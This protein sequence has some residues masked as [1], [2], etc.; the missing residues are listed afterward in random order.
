MPPTGKRRRRDYP[1]ITWAESKQLYRATLPANEHRAARRDVY[2]KT[3]DEILDKIDIIE[4]EEKHGVSSATTLSQLAERWA[5]LK[6]DNLS[7]SSRKAYSNALRNHIL[8]NL[9]NMPLSAIK[10]IH[11]DELLSSLG[12]QSE[13]L[14]SRVL[15]TLRQIM[16]MAIE[17]DLITKN[18]CRNKKSGG[19]KARE[20]VPLSHEQQT[21]LA[22]AVKGT[23]AELFVL[24]CMY[25]GLRRE[26]ALGLLWSDVHLEGTPYIDVR[27]T[28]TFE[29]NNAVFS[30]N[31]KTKSAQR[32]IPIPPQLSTALAEAKGTANSV[33]VVT[34]TI[35]HMSF[36]A[37][38]NMWNIVSGR[39]RKYTD[40]DGKKVVKRYPGCVD[41]HVHPHLLRHTYITELCASGMDI[42]KI[43]YLAG[44]A[45]AKMTLNVYSHVTQNRPEQ[46]APAIIKTFTAGIVA[47]NE[48]AEASK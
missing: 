1:P 38:V 42:K 2:G 48:K 46:L 45:D 19:I 23:R 11:V 21:T 32:T 16:E 12:S 29:K 13:G 20:K 35:N 14:H 25:A 41:F 7:Y 8:P 4:A 47:G 5:A 26:E 24:L 39:T 31:L 37:Y 17:N 44:H 30:D 28:I 18:P 36:S 34:S 40:K 27:H 6:T 43:Q 33:F 10:P 9:G 3:E 22:D 15:G